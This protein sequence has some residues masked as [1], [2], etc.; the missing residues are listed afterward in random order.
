MN[1]ITKPFNVDFAIKTVEKIVTRQLD[2]I[3]TQEIK[4]EILECI[5][6]LLTPLVPQLIT[7]PNQLYNAIWARIRNDYKQQVLNFIITSTS[8]LMMRLASQGWDKAIVVKF[9][10]ET[11]SI[12]TVLPSLEEDPFNEQ[13]VT[14][15]DLEIML[16]GNSWYIFVILLT[17]TTLRSSFLQAFTEASKGSRN[18]PK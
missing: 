2:G 15:K 3:A 18:E 8:E 5:V 11:L 1:A 6:S 7:N 4:M 14:K 13:V 9:L 12:E 16:S 10:T 17:M